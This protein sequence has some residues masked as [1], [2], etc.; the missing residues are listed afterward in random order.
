M[1]KLK[2]S[3]KQIRDINEGKVDL[4]QHSGDAGYDLYAASAPKIKGE[5]YQGYLFKNISYI[6]Y[7]TNISIEPSSDDY[8]D[9]DFY[10]LLFP[11]SSI[12]KYNL[13]LCNSVGVIDSGYRDTIKIRFR[14]IPQ[15]EN[16]SIL[17]EKH[18]LLGVDNSKIYQKGDRIAQLI[19]SKHLHPRVEESKNQNTSS[20][21][22]GGF[23]STG[24]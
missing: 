7:E 8:S 20:R 5:I 3:L 2:V 24:K 21:G 12:S 23:G 14:Y 1:E 16:Y 15:P 10:S 6:E 4:P 11:R 13:S 18:L 19:F 22:K 9:Y 17:N